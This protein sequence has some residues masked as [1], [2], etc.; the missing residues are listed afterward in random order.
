MRRALLIG[1]VAT[2]MGAVA[3]AQAVAANPPNL[4]WQTDGAV[5]AIAFS[6]GV[7]YVGGQFS[8]VRPPG[9]VLG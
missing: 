3:P 8:A 7:M 9:A 6:G 2:A 4:S 5:R 1:A